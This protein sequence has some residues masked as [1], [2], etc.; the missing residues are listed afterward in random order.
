MD[1]W[2]DR[3]KLWLAVQFKW[4]GIAG[5]SLL[6]LVFGNYWLG[7]PLK[8]SFVYVVLALFAAVIVLRELEYRRRKKQRD[9]D[10]RD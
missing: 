1:D 7:W 5:A 10:E 6:V 8:D 4:M 2:V 9:Q 3:A